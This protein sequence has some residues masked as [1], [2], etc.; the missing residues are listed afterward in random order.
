MES[1]SKRESA[2]EQWLSRTAKREHGDQIEVKACRMVVSEALKLKVL[3]SQVIQFV[4]NASTSLIRQDN[5]QSF[6]I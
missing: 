3:T 1:K 5:R 6:W 2:A 4:K